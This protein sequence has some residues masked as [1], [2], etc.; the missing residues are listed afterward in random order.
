MRTRSIAI[1][2]LIAVSVFWMGLQLGAEQSVK[3]ENAAAM[4]EAAKGAL[5]AT[6]ASQEAGRATIED[7][8]QW[9]RRLM[10]AEALAGKADA[11]ADHFDRMGALH[12]KAAALYKKGAKGGSE[13]KFYATKF[14]LLEAQNNDAK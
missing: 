11:G 9:S 12:Q 10:T 8:Y 2:G 1:G 3:S 6:M 5:R 13:E 4:V 14:Y 7:V